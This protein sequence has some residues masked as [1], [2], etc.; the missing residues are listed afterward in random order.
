MKSAGLAL[1]L[2]L[3]TLF[4]MGH[5]PIAPGT[6]ASAAVAAFTLGLACSGAGAAA[7][8]ATLLVIALVFASV[9]VLFGR[10]AEEHYGQTDPHQVVADEVAG[11]CIALLFLPWHHPTEPRALLWN[12]AIATTALVAFRFFDILKP[13]PI[14]AS[15]RFPHGWGILVDD[16]LAG[17]LALAIAHLAALVLA[18]AVL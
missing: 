7:I 12:A 3:L 9:C 13:P 11:Q 14:R 17:A 1:G 2:A 6:W 8:N 5:L 10:R 15:Q 18:R 4:G 16:L